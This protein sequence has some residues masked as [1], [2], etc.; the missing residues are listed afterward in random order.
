MIFSSRHTKKAPKLIPASG[1]SLLF[2]YYCVVLPENIVTRMK[3][4]LDAQ[5]SGASAPE[6]SPRR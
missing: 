2:S 1:P 5:Q 6:G 3:A 4:Y